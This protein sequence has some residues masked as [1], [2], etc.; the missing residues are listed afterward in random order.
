MRKY[1]ATIVV[2]YKISN[3]YYKKIQLSLLYIGSKDKDNINGE[4]IIDRIK[5]ILI[6]R[7]NL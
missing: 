1:I 2:N 3:T 6:A 5:W 7:G 4:N